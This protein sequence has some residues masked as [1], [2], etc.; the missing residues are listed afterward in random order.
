MQDI[1]SDLCTCSD[2]DN[3]ILGPDL[4][5]IPAWMQLQYSPKVKKQMSPILWP[6]SKCCKCVC[7]MCMLCVCVIALLRASSPGLSAIYTEPQSPRAAAD[8]QPTAMLLQAGSAAFWGVGRQGKGWGKAGLSGGGGEKR[9]NLCP[10]LDWA[11]L[12]STSRFSF[13]ETLISHTND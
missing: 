2:L 8:M 1:G 4:I 12:L 3:F 13:G 9:W 11:A 5:Q 7:V 10:T 6:F